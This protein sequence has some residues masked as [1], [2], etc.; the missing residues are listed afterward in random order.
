MRD[1]LQTRPTTS[2]HANPARNTSA[3]NPSVQ[4]L[5]WPTLPLLGVVGALVGALPAWLSP[6]QAVPVGDLSVRPAT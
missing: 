2:R 6:P 5:V 3:L 1:G 4:P